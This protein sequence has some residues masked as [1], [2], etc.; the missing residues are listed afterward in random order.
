MET[1]LVLSVSNIIHKNPRHVN[2]LWRG[3]APP[4]Q[5]PR[6][7]LTIWEIRYRIKNMPTNGFDLCDLHTHTTFSD[8][9][10]TPEEVLREAEARGCRVGIADHCG[11]GSFQ[12]SDNL[13]FDRY[14]EALAPLPLLRSAELDLGNPGRVTADRLARCDYLIAGVH[15]LEW[16]APG[17]RADFFDPEAELPD[18]GRLLGLMLALIGEGAREHRFHILAHPGL[19]PVG[20][21][22]RGEELLGDRW[23]S[24]IIGLALEH[25]FAL[26]ISSRWE[27]PGRGLI[28]K[29]Q[30]AGV[31][32]S[33]GSDGHVRERMCRLDYSLAMV[34]ECGLG[35]GDLLAPAPRAGVS[36][37][38]APT[39]CAR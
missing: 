29:A 37:T 27:L 28:R 24:G 21:R 5:G 14:L 17:T 1:I 9:K 10:M 33:L 15:S 35:P 4:G 38:T 22:D 23:E 36:S 34:A 7:L 39:G 31:R 6:F 11:R 32:F 16:P 13:K 19:L 2:T 20:L 26:E 25:G 18:P 30:R 8:G 12:L 3:P